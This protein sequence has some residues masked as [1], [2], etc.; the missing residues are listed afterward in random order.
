MGVK[1]KI[2]SQAEFE[3]AAKEEVGEEKE[4]IKTD[5]EAL[6][7][8]IAKSPHL[9]KIRQDEQHLL[10]FLR[11]CKFSLERTKEKIDFYNS[12][13]VNAE[14]FFSDW[15]VESPIFRL[16]NPTESSLEEIM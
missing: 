9:Q 12:C 14:Q 5:I 11:G 10:W 2:F 15:D 3:K 7:Q 8:W 1:M 6:Q 13:R 16:M 4:R